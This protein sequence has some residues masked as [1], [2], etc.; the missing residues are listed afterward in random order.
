MSDPVLPDRMARLRLD[1]VRSVPVPW[2]VAWVDGQPDFRVIGPDR[3]RDALR[4]KLCWL[5]GQSMGRYSTFVIGPMC[6]VNRVSAEPPSHRDC[7]IYA[8]QACP[9]L[10][11]PD[12]RRR[13]SQLPDGVS[14]PAGEMIRRNPGVTL[15]WT[16]KAFTVWNPRDGRGVLIDIGEPHEALWFSHGRAATRDEVEASIESGLPLLHKMAEDEGPKAVAQLQRQNEAARVLLP[17][18]VS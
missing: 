1:P 2:F 4:F 18:G 17:G 12:R 14:N 7:A 5:C 10:A 11:N 3:I 15:V 6:A 16:T 9:F 13:E 8:A